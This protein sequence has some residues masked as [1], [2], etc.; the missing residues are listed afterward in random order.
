MADLA[1]TLLMAKSGVW[2]STTKELVFLGRSARSRN[3][4]PVLQLSNY[5]Y[6]NTK[7]EQ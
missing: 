2:D 5:S 7:K 6:T 1:K 4:P 3:N